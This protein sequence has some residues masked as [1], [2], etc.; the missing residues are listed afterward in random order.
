MN[1]RFPPSR[2][3]GYG[4]T[5]KERDEAI[6]QIWTAVREI[7][8]SIASILAS[9]PPCKESLDRLE[10]AMD[11]N[12]HA[13]VKSR[14]HVLETEMRWLWAAVGGLATGLAAVGVKVVDW[15]MRG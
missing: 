13:G 10:S 4:M 8:V 7:Q 5:D 9:C 6:S 3:K 14:V 11:G 1:N 15:W 12:G 2:T